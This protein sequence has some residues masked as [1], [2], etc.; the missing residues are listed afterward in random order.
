M[1]LKRQ[2]HKRAVLHNKSLGPVPRQLQDEGMSP[3]TGDL[4]ERKMGSL[5]RKRG[6]QENSRR[7]SRKP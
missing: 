3:I 4:Q 2:D 5:P 1:E 6:G 7:N